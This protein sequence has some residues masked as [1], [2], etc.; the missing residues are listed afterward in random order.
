[1]AAYDT[2][3]TDLFRVVLENGSGSV[4]AEAI[5]SGYAI[6]RYGFAARCEE[7]ALPFREGRFSQMGLRPREHSPKLKK[8]TG[9]G[10]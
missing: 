4:S 6:R 3:D 7:V 8:P 2:T 1:M 9:G 5:R 10:A